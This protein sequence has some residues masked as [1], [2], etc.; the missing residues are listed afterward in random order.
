MP[1][2]STIVPNTLEGAATQQLSKGTD[3]ET[4][5]R[6][7]SP[8]RI[9][10]GRTLVVPRLDGVAV[11]HASFGSD[12]AAATLARI[13]LELDIA[14]AADWSLCGG[15]PEKFIERTIDRFVRGHGESE[16][17]GA[18]ELSLTLSTEPHEWYE[19]E[20]EPDGSQM[21]LYMEASSC[22]FVNLGPALALCEREHARLPATFARLFLESLGSCFRIYDDHDA[23]E[24]ISILEDNYDPSEDAEAL[25]ALPK[26]DA[27]LPPSMQQRVLGT[28][29][30]KGIVSRLAPR[31]HIYR[32]LMAT[33][34]V[35]RLSRAVK[36]P[37]IPEPV[38]EMFSDCNPPVPILLAIYRLGDAIEAAFDDERQSMLEVTPE[39]WPL[40]PFNGTDRE[41]TREAFNCLGAALDLLVAARRVLNL[42]PSWEA[43]RAI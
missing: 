13:L 40:I 38:R 9:A 1:G 34:E 18:F 10:P 37:Q 5:G 21:F 20:D 23:E 30:L 32:L 43:N 42:V 33:L 27:I 12:Q 39:P 22:G 14:R 31:S 16:I 11:H 28:K 2:I 24:H 15:E 19:A 29:G 26:R 41:S 17:D 6:P 3:H 4:A 7:G 35:A 8:W 25:A 36:L